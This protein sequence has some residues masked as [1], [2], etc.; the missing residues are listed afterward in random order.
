ME[1]TN[2]QD[3]KGFLLVYW[4]AVATGYQMHEKERLV[5]KKN[6][7]VRTLTR[8]DLHGKPVD[9]PLYNPLVDSNLAQAYQQLY[10]IDVRFYAPT[11]EWV[12]S[13]SRVATR[14]HLHSFSDY[15]VNAALA[16][17]CVYIHVESPRVP[18]N[19]LTEFIQNYTEELML[20][21]DKR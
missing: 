15:T 1:T 2:I 19:E 12:A 13:P 10:K 17:A 16:K 9:L 20:S 6:E 8:L 18:K 3:L 14:S 7:D 5:I 4:F 11:Q 21:Y